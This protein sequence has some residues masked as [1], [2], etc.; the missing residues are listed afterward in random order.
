MNTSSLLARPHCAHLLFA[1]ALLTSLFVFHGALTRLVSLPAH[2]YRYSHLPLIPVISVGLIYFNRD[3]IFLRSQPSLRAG[4]ILCVL[5]V[6]TLGLA[7][8]GILPLGQE[9]RLILE[10]LALVLFWVA[11][12]ICLYGAHALRNAVFPMSLLVLMI[13]PPLS[14]M[15]EL[16][17]FLQRRSADVTYV[18]FKAFGVPVHREGFLFSLP[19]MQIE[20]TDD[21]S[22]FR[23]TIASVIT[24]LIAGY[25]LLHSKW[26]KACLVVAA[27]P[28]VIFKNAIRIMALWWLGLHVSRAFLFGDLHRYSGLIFSI[29]SFSL[30][31]TLLLA[32][33][34]R[35]NRGSNAVPPRSPGPGPA[36]PPTRT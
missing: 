13:P 36:C 14:F 2:D 6:G 23:S 28:V 31:A 9:T 17:G 32:L 20:I 4:V 15:E 5:A 30:L 27:I 34:W 26:S 7:A 24:A 8:N 22:G 1:I 33:W 3:R 11:A 19:D 10:V 12:F 25:L 35:E 18:L 16:A 29:L 21:C